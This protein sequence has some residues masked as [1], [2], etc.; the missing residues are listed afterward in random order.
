MNTQRE[1]RLG[2]FDSFRKLSFVWRTLLLNLKGFSTTWWTIKKNQGWVI[3]WKSKTGV[4]SSN[5]RVT[6]S[7]LQVTNSNPPVTSS[8]LQ[9]TSSNLRVRRLKARVAK[10]KTW[11]GTLKARVGGRIVY[12]VISTISSLFIFLFTKRFWAWK[13]HPNVSKRFSPS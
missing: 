6:S 11:V 13:K 8:N 10:L 7:N 12:E 1:K 3:K 4:T 5:P 2:K 9:V